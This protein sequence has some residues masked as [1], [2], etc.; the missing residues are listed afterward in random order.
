L[1]W[2]LHRHLPVFV[3]GVFLGRLSGLSHL[4]HFIMTANSS[5]LIGP[6]S[7]RDVQKHMPTLT[8]TATNQTAGPLAFMRGPN[9][10]GQITYNMTVFASMTDR[11]NANLK[12]NYY[13]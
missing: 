9:A 1:S 11:T 3:P 12:G 13:S 6:D 4:D 10:S 5:P 7:Y 2:F 8:Q